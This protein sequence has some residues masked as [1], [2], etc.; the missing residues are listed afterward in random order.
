[1]SMKTGVEN[2]YE[3]VKHENC[4]EDFDKK[5]KKSVREN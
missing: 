1:M 4:R 2:V 3:M 5:K